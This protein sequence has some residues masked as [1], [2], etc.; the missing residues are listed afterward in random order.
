M[1][2]IGKYF[3]V[4]F[5][6]ITFF[7]FTAVNALNIPCVLEE[8]ELELLAPE[9]YL[10]VTR[11]TPEDS[12]ILS[13]LGVTKEEL[14]DIYDALDIHMILINTE[15]PDGGDIQDMIQLTC[16]FDFSSILSDEVKKMDYDFADMTDEY[17]NNIAS[18]LDALIETTDQA[19]KEY[20]T[21]RHPQTGFIK[22]R[23][24]DED[25]DP[26]LQYYTIHNDIVYRFKLLSFLDEVTP[27]QEANMKALIDSVNFTADPPATPV[28]PAP[29]V[30]D[31]SYAPLPPSEPFRPDAP[32]GEPFSPR[33]SQ[34]D[35]SFNTLQAF[36]IILIG[37]LTVFLLVVVIVSKKRNKKVSYSPQAAPVSYQP[38]QQ[39]ISYQP[40]QQPVSYQP[41]DSPSPPPN[42]PYTGVD[43]YCKNCGAKIDHKAN[44][45]TQC[46]TKI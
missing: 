19:S 20:S 44:F 10:P 28:T 1:K 8:P 36:C 35:R 11:D 15:F 14:V 31:D 38:S 2:I 23:Y 22:V 5:C 25:G 33:S 21:Y 37:V 32:S 46:G 13:I 34:A 42:A 43:R 3:S 29:P 4:L 30:L 16:T 27:T 24:L 7:S 45:C 12:E 9:G 39:P 18:A 17:L 41:I 40:S 6:L 26:C